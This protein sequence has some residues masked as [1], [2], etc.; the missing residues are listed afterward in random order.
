MKNKVTPHEALVRVL[1]V[2]ETEAC[3]EK[4]DGLDLF[5]YALSPNRSV[6]LIYDCLQQ[7]LSALQHMH[8]E[9]VVHCDVK[10]D[11][12]RILANGRAKLFDYGA[13]RRIGEPIVEFTSAFMDT[14]RWCRQY[15]PPPAHPSMD[16]Y[17]FCVTCISVL[18]C[19][20]APDVI[21]A[22]N[23]NNW[24]EQC[25]FNTL[26]TEEDVSLAYTNSKTLAQ[27][28]YSLNN[29]MVNKKNSNCDAAL[30]P[31][32]IQ[33]VLD[34]LGLTVTKLHALFHVSEDKLHEWLQSGAE[35]CKLHGLSLQAS[36]PS[37]CDASISS[38]RRKRRR[39]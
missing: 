8:T 14:T 36:R 7:V 26:L 13:V 21:N 9:G 37:N 10:P 5:D 22:Q 18:F 2:T 24:I 23:I 27:A 34:P 25:V 33:K 15:C 4:L 31:H 32:V 20:N 19:L 29:N 39:K 35:K 3:L 38:P 30:S 12:V 28:R 1:E 16:T 6:L 17:A 11:N